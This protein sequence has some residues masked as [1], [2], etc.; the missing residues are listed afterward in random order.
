M[1]LIMERWDRFVVSESPSQPTTWGELGTNIILS[2]AASRFPRIATSLARFGFKASTAMFRQAKEQ[3]QDLED[4]LDFIPD[5]IQQ[6]LEKGSED[7]AKW[8]TDQAKQRGGQIGAFIV[9]DLIGMDDS[10]TKK[11]PGYKQLNIDDEYEN[12]VDKKLLKKW[13]V[14]IIR[15]AKEMASSN[16]DVPLPNLNKE[17]EDWFQANIGAHP[18]TDPPDIRPDNAP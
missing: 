16:P 5:E 3:I 4:I 13:A 7:A 12:L 8:L 2:T 1:K 9:D 18:D 10:L 6:K 11:L 14:G 15:K 17:L